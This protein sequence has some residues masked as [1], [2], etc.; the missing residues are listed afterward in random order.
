MYKSNIY[1]DRVRWQISTADTL[2]YLEFSE[3]SLTHFTKAGALD[4]TAVS[5]KL[6]IFSLQ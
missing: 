6:T 3:Q 2:L 5:R 4:P 1:F